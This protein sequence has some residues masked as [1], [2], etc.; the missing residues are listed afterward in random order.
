[1]RRALAILS[2]LRRARAEAAA[3]ELVKTFGAWRAG[4]IAKKMSGARCLQTERK[5]I[6]TVAFFYY[7]YYN[8]GVERVMSLLIPKFQA[9]GYRTVLL[10]EEKN[11][12]DYPLPENC[13]KIVLPTSIECGGE[14][15]AKHAKALGEALRK[16]GVDAL[17]YQAAS[18]ECLLF[19][20]LVAKGCGVRFYVSMH[21]AF[22]LP[23][24]LRGQAFASS[25]YV[26]RLA[27]GVQTLM[28]SDAAL[29][30]ANGIN[31]HYITNPVDF[32]VAVNDCLNYVPHNK[33]ETAF[34]K[35]CG[36]LKK[37]GA[38]VF[39]IS[40]EYKLKN[41]LGNN[42]FADDED[43]ITYIWF[44]K[45]LGDSVEMDITVFTAAGGG[46]FKR[47]DERHIQYAHKI[48]DVVAALESAGFDVVRTEGH[49]GEPL[50]SDSLRANFICLR[51]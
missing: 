6:K 12:K 24:M 21:E 22:G 35:V 36:C 10:V 40:T 29:L 2:L 4:E 51:R 14:G 1:M 37:G 7:R 42:L 26:L 28:R 46:L 13:P 38:F 41:V 15:Y 34:K 23:L 30:C 43:D 17:L 27:D 11:A 20:M 44:N 39:D 5:E 8:G 32:A 25:P 16:Y 47:E 3:E 31:A 49:L 50:E 9:W 19:D 45:W 33:L 18:S 48:P